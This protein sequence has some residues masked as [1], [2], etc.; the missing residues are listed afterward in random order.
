MSHTVLSMPRGPRYEALGGGFYRC[1]PLPVVVAEESTDTC[2]EN[3][4]EPSHHKI[5]TSIDD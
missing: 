5:R 1:F 4:S 2:T 3:L